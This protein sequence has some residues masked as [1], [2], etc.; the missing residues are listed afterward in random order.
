MLGWI[1][2]SPKQW[3]RISQDFFKENLLCKSC[4]WVMSWNKLTELLKPIYRFMRYNKDNRIY[5]KIVPNFR[6][7]YFRSF[8]NS[9]KRKSITSFSIFRLFC[10]FLNQKIVDKFQTEFS[11]NFFKKL[12]RRFLLH[13]LVIVLDTCTNKSRQNL[14]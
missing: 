13:F 1:Y 7:N 2:W 3:W 10:S 4:T 11:A 6:V 12:I 5:P 9:S 8:I 14:S